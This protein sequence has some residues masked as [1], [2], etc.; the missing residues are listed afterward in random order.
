[1][2]MF[3]RILLIALLCALVQTYLP[4]W[5]CAVIAFSVE[6]VFGKGRLG[7]FSGF[8]GVA[9]A[10][11]VLAAYIDHSSGSVLTY[12][13]LE[14]FKLP[15]MAMVLIIVTGLVGGIAGGLSSMAGSWVNAYFR[16]ER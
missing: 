12:R 8:Y 2:H 1:M 3:I 10:W 16:N 11:M 4:W 9:A 5:S 6:A 7:F 15:A 13:I 14:L